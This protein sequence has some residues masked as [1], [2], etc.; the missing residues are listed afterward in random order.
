V[1]NLLTLL[2]SCSVGA[3][4]TESPHARHFTTTEVQTL[5]RALGHVYGPHPWDRPLPVSRAPRLED[6]CMALDGLGTEEGRTLAGE[7][8]GIFVDS[9]LGA[10]FNAPT[11]VDLSFRHRAVC[12]NV[13]SIDE[14][15]RPWIYAVLFQRMSRYIFTRDVA[16]AGPLLILVDEARHMLNEPRV[17]HGVRDLVKRI[18]TRHAALWLAD[19]DISTYT[20]TDIGQQIVANSPLVFFGRMEGPN[21]EQLRPLFPRLTEWHTH[22][23][24]TARPGQFVF[25]EYDNYYQ[26]RVEPS[27][28]E[29]LAFAGT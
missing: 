25:K 5:Y 18:R 7:I 14:T 20:T 6:L 4:N 19:Q 8:G 23:I 10:I 15:F 12:F 1:V 28:D 11:N 29:L 27:P 2:L 3:N 13:H 17:A 21:I 22:G 24:I 9:A 16:T 26:L